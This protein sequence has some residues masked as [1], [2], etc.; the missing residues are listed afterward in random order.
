MTLT[1]LT[2]LPA[3]VADAMTIA[4][5]YRTRW[6]IETAFQKLE[7]HLHSEIKTLTLVANSSDQFTRL[8]E[9]QQI[10]N[11][12]LVRWVFR[13]ANPQLGSG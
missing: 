6:G 9:A 13:S 2:N 1:I 4:E 10:A 7:Q 3:A 5:L 12:E 8:P 11:S